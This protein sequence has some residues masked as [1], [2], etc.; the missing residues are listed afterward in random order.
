MNTRNIFWC[1]WLIWLCCPGV[2]AKPVHHYVF[3]GQE[4]EKIKTAARLMIRLIFH[5]TCAAVLLQVSFTSCQAQTVSRC[6]PSPPMPN[7]PKPGVIGISLSR[8]GKTL[9]TAGTDG[10]IRVWNVATGQMQRT[11]TGHT[12]SIYKAEFS[13]NEKLIASASRDLTAR[14]WDFATGRELYQLTGFKCSVKSLAFSP[15]GKML[16]VVGNDGMLKL[17]DVETGRELKSLVHSSSPDVDISVYSVIFSRDGKRIYTGNGDGAISEWNAAAGKETNIWKAHKDTVIALAFSPDYRWLA[18]QNG[19]NEPTV[20]LWE[21]ETRRELR[22]FG[23]KKT[24]GLLEQ[25]HTVAFSPNGKMIASSVSGF[26]E[27]QGQFVYVR[28]YVWNVATGEK[29][30]TFA[31]QKFD[32][33]GLVFTSDNRFLISGSAD[34]T[35]KFYDLKTGRETRTLTQPPSSTTN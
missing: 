13:P 28:T 25:A 17:W 1:A 27:K 35:I 24:A 8:D 2:S 34:T 23:E 29:L 15:D 11:L 10:I 33:G 9:V 32:V 6:R 16:A 21:V 31:G 12:N 19:S 20:K 4:R 3:F 30:F 7:N 5:L 26:D 14:I 22:A 18:S